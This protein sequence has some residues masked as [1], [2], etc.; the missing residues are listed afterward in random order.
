MR[1]PTPTRRVLLA[2]LAAVCLSPWRVAGQ[3][4]PR[5]V[6][7]LDVMVLDATIVMVGRFVETFPPHVTGPGR[8]WTFA[9]EK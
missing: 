3:D 6:P 4:G 8:T 5:R 9:V 7:N 1:T 2:I